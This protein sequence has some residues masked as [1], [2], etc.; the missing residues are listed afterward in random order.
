MSEDL[1]KLSDSDQL[2]NK[3]TIDI[4]LKE[5]GRKYSRV[6][7]DRDLCIGAGTCIAVAPEAF[8]LDSEAKA[9]MKDTWP[10]IDDETLKAAAESCP[11]LAVYLYNQQNKKVF[12]EE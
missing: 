1:T 5:K 9:I 6:V 3:N 2:P 8:E 10:E 11:V 4:K 7:V 12:P